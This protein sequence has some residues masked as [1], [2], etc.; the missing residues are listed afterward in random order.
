MLARTVGP[1]GRRAKLSPQDYDRGALPAGEGEC[2]S[3][4]PA[5]TNENRRPILIRSA[6]VWGIGAGGGNRCVA[7]VVGRRDTPT[8][9]TPAPSGAALRPR[10]P[11]VKPRHERPSPALGKPRPA[12]VPACRSRLNESS[13]S[14]ADGLP[15]ESPPLRSAP[16]SHF[17]GMTGRVGTRP[18]LVAIAYQPRHTWNT[19]RAHVRHRSTLE[20]APQPIAGTSP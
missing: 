12:R 10:S 7:P 5:T 19:R 20:A 1:V 2:A 15:G 9:E 16:P 18:H 17:G 14:P 4:Q 13:G 11:S 3:P 6:D 8:S